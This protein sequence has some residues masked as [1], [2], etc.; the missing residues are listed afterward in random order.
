MSFR[1]KINGPM[2]F[3]EFEDVPCASQAIKE[4]YGHNL[5]SLL[6]SAAWYGV[7]CAE[8]GK[9]NLPALMSNPR[10]YCL[11]RRIESRSLQFPASEPALSTQN[12]ASSTRVA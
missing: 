12:T 8:R 10:L 5:V 2:C 6:F 1:Q 11:T 7:G 9:A 4:L 3:V